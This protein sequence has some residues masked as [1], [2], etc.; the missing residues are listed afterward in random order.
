MLLDEGGAA[1][2]AIS[3]P[4]TVNREMDGLISG[5]SSAVATLPLFAR[6]PDFADGRLPAS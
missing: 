6:Q 3:L 4:P 1:D 2:S 5:E